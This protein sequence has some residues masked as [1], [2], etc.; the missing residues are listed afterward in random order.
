MPVDI[1]GYIYAAAIA[2]GGIAGYVKAGSTTSLGAGL[3]FGGLAGL[4]AYRTS[5]DPKDVWFMIG[6][7]ASLGAM[8][9]WRFYGSKKFMP[10][11]MV[12]LLSVGILTKN[13]LSLMS[14]EK[15]ST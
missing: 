1:V 7:S 8:M 6:V 3:L 10:A 9:G 2:A 15:K 4:G 13:I 12:A 14:S 11:G 5:K